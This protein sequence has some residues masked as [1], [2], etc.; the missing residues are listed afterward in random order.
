MPR[1]I[2]PK[3]KATATK[4][5][6][7]PEK[8][9]KTS[10]PKPAIIGKPIV[11]KPTVS[12]KAA[13]PGRKPGKTAAKTVVSKP[14]VTRKPRGPYRPRAAK[15]AAPAR[16]QRRLARPAPITV[17]QTL[18]GFLATVHAVFADQLAL[19]VHQADSAT[20]ET[21]AVLLSLRK[22]AG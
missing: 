8:K 7:P 1:R 2:T 20:R 21:I 11:S 19:A 10:A 6:V 9:T 4:K 13:K 12:K 18:D 15:V 17:P 5:S 22:V 16:R 3:S 14:L